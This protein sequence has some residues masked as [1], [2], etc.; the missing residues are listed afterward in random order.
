MGTTGSTL[1]S[2]SN[3]RAAPPALPLSARRCISPGV[4]QFS[5]DFQSII[6][7]AVQ[8]ADIPVQNLQNEQ[9]TN[10]AD[11]ECVDRAGAD[12]CRAGHRRHELGNARKQSGAVGIQLGC[13]YGFGSEHGGNGAG[14]LYRF[15]YHFAC[16]RGLG[17]FSGRLRGTAAVSAS[18]LV[19]L[20][21]GS[22]TYQTQSHRQRV[23]IMSSGLAQAINNANAGV[24]ATVLTAGSTDYLGVSANNTG[25]TTLQLN[26][27]NATDLVSNTGTGTETSTQTYADQTTAPVS[28]TGQV[29]LTVGPKIYSLSVSPSNN[30]LNWSGGGH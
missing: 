1:A 5:S 14:H 17:N 8:I 3:A 11:A 18:G 21:V 10:T 6:Q 16:V 27:V 13:E 25:A 20:V 12:G 19:N 24:S 4:S 30:N 9:A 29:E 23:R 26:S 7:R 22:N 2:A 15:R 28:A